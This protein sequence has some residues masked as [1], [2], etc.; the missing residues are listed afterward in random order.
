MYN[1]VITLKSDL[2]A[3]DGDGFAS[4]IDSDICTDRFGM[5]IIPARRIKGCLRNAAQFIFE[6][7]NAVIDEIFGKTGSS[8]G[9]KLHISD[10][11][12]L[13]SDEISQAVKTSHNITPAMVTD[14]F[15]YTRASTAI[16]D[17]SGAAEDQSLRFMRVVKHFDPGSGEEVQFSARV[18]IPEKYAVKLDRICR[19]L[20]NIGLKRNRG[21]GAVSCRLVKARG[22]I[23]SIPEYSFSADR[24]YTIRYIVRLTD[25]VMISGG[26]SDESLDFIP[27]T[28]LLG[29]FAAEYLKNHDADSAFE[30]IFLKNGVRFSN[31]Y[32]SDKNGSE[33]YPV[34]VV[35]G[36]IK[37]VPHAVNVIKYDTVD[38]THIVKPLKSGYTNN[39]L[40]IK[41]PL[42]ETVYHISMGDGGNLY[43]QTAIRNGQYFSGTVSG[44]GEL[45]QSIYDIM[46]GGIIRVG[47]S[48]TAQYSSC[49]ILHDGFLV[50]PYETEKM[51]IRKGE[52]FVAA[53]ASDLLIPNGACGY[54][55]DMKSFVRAVSAAFGFGCAETDAGMK[56]KRSAL[57][58][59]N[60]LGFNT[61]WKLS[62]PHVRAVAAGS[63]AVSPRTGIMTFQ[64]SC[65]LATETARVSAA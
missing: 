56:M 62:K 3:A 16:N 5:P 45:I 61:Q 20:R 57:R 60:I 64:C 48:K 32:I 1:I 23:Q 39:S 22:D 42:T 24:E 34:P 40:N 65:G 9:C 53:A 41:Y 36:K 46:R 43:T 8:S 10:A 50:V 21:L 17:K 7:N 47:R 15:T 29:F 52:I 31:L 6:G 14:L 33:Y 58:Y 44:R 19:A 11:H 37:G 2:C 4:A 35:V 55:S 49:R 63:A 30:D 38:D 27:G 12:L 25:D 51:H 59:R 28:S 54:A 18:E 26:S 13:N